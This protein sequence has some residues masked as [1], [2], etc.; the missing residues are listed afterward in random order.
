MEKMFFRCLFIMSIM[1]LYVVFGIDVPI[2]VLLS[3]IYF[4]L[5]DIDEG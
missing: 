4:K 2:I 5:G 1:F 3:F